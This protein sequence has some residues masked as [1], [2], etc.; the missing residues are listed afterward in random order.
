MSEENL[1]M[2]VQLCDNT[3]VVT[4]E[5]GTSTVAFHSAQALSMLM[6]CASILFSSVSA[7]PD[8]VVFVLV[9]VALAKRLIDIDKV[10]DITEALRSN[11]KS[12]T[13]SNR[14]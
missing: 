4:H 1:K 5:E 10:T 8:G 13:L 11:C 9:D 14:M 7:C 2:L 6:K 12:Y 3:R